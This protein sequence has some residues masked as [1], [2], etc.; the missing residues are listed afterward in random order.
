MTV[1][2][3]ALG[4]LGIAVS[5]GAQHFVSDIIA[6]LTIVF[7]GIFH[8]GDVV[9]LGGPG[10]E[11]HGEVRE[12]GLRFIRLQ[13]RHGNIV[14]LSNRDISMI[15]NMTQLNSR[16]E[17]SLVLSS[18]Y[19][20]D[21]IEEMLQR[22]LPKISEMDRRILAG[23]TYNGITQFDNGTMT[24]SIM[25]ECSEEDLFDVQQIVNRS[26]QRIFRENGYRI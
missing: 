9:D 26:L 3:A 19:S 18:E 23:P 16:Y 1:I 8:V 13:T 14:T 2:V 10:R 22:E 5:L 24:L 25:T 4:T 21:D 20:I 15:N 11:Y 6:G 7:E 12:I 17:C